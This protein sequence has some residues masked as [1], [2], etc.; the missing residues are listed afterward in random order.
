MSSR[1]GTAGEIPG[2]GPR[3]SPPLAPRPVPGRP[4]ARR[5]RERQ[6]TTR[7]PPAAGSRGQRPP[8]ETHGE[9]LG[10][11]IPDLSWLRPLPRQLAAPQP[12]MH[13]RIERPKVSDSPRRGNH[14]ASRPAW[15][16][17]PGR[18]SRSARASSK[19]QPASVPTEGSGPQPI[20][21]VAQT[22]SGCFWPGPRQGLC[23]V[24]RRSV[25]LATSARQS[26]ALA[27][28]GAASVPVH[29]RARPSARAERALHWSLA[30]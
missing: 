5:R 15:T 17:G 8:G 13:D 28:A 26:Q 9:V 3:L 29:D 2:P 24:I 27:G 21:N 11:F 4:T 12:L 7:T 18:Q 1:S 16:A 25:Q 6:V 23:R 20:A 22:H 14:H 19:L 10:A 30:S